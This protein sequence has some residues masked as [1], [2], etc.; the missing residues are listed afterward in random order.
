M[1]GAQAITQCICLECGAEI[2]EFG[3]SGLCATCAHIKSWARR[4]LRVPDEGEIV[5]KRIS[6]EMWQYGV[7]PQCRGCRENCHQYAA[8]HSRIL[9]CKRIEPPPEAG[10]YLSTGDIHA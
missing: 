1:R 4:K 6:Y 3:K 8:P 2:T 5:K 10:C 9:Y 7:H